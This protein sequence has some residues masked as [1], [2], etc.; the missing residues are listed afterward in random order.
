MEQEIGIRINPIIIYTV[1]AIP[2]LFILFWLYNVLRHIVFPNKK[3]I[4]GFFIETSRSMII[5]FLLL[6]L[7]ASGVL[8][9]RCEAPNLNKM[10][11]YKKD[12]QY[13]RV[14]PR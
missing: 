9:Y 10:N 11:D 8:I 6:L 2:A 5:I 3:A 4:K 1:I 13:D 12:V 7:L 14:V